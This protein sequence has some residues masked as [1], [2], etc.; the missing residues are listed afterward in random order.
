M[1]EYLDDNPYAT[2]AEHASGELASEP[3]AMVNALLAIAAEIRAVRIALNRL[4][5]GN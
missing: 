5:V 4:P 1:S 3:V 2:F